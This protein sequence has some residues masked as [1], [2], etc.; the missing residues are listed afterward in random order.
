LQRKEP[1]ANERFSATQFQDLWG[2]QAAVGG[3]SQWTQTC[4]PDYFKQPDG[5]P[6]RIVV[7]ET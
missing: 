1:L 4:Q 3:G 6:L 5:G 7:R 2:R